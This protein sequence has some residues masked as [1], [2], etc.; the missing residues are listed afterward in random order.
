MKKLFDEHVDNML[1]FKRLKCE[2]L[3]PAPELNAVQSLCKLLEVLAI[4]ENGVKFTG[5]KDAF[6][7]ICKIWFF[8]WYVLLIK[9]KTLK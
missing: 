1:T 4:P 2:E 8:F 3:V 9:I 5:D 6:T 7:H